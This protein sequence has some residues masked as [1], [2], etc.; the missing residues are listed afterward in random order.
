L[1]EAH[2]FGMLSVGVRARTQDRQM[3]RFPP[4]WLPKRIGAFRASVAGAT[5]RLRTE[6]DY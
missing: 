1:R 4:G 5:W 3:T 2:G 6:P